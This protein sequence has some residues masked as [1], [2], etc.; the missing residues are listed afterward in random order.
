MRALL[1]THAAIFLWEGRREVFGVEATRVLETHTLLLSPFSRLEMKYLLE[2]GRLIVEPDLIIG[3]LEA[4]CKVTMSNTAVA[5]VVTHAMALSWTRDPFDRLLVAT[6]TL[7]AS[8]LVTR[9]RAIREH[10]RGAVW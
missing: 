9:D 1:D 7:Q 3:G 10:F 2:I 4:D 6:A 5:E 8:K